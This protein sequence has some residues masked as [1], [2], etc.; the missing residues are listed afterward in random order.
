MG[1]DADKV[2]NVAHLARL[3]LNSG[4]VGKYAR[5][6]SDIL[7]MADRL[8]SVDAG[9]VTPMAHPLELSQRMRADDV[10]ETDERDRFQEKA[11]QVEAGLYLVPRV[12]E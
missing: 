11:P 6:L 12:I 4:D 8:G 3:E 7:A 9:S 1:L 2:K 10:T 5:D